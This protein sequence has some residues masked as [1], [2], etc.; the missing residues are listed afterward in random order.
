MRKDRR[1]KELERYYGLRA[2]EY[3]EM[4]SRADAVRQEELGRAADMMRRMVRGR[5]V[6]EVAC[7][8]GYWTQIASEVA[9]EIVAV[10]TSEEMLSLAAEKEY[11][12]DNVRFLKADAY[13]LSGVEGRFDAGVAGFWL[14][15]VPKGRLVSFLKGFHKRVG[16]G[17]PVFMIDN[18]NVPGFGG[19]CVEEPGCEDTFKRRELK[20]GSKYTVIKN[21]FDVSD[22]ERLFEPHSKDLEIKRGTYYWW[23][24]YAIVMM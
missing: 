10:D 7:G 23:L 20:D 11:P 1:I 14:S 16:V 15:H 8:T 13:D 2:N 12:Y 6:L 18:F 24:K 9:R 3:E 22:L 17:A 21:Y 4:Y 19:E 5:G